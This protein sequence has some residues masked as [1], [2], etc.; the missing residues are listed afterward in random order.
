MIRRIALAAL[1]AFLFTPRV[2]GAAE[3]PPKPTA[4]EAKVVAAMSVD[5]QKRFPTPKDAETAGYVRYT[6]EDETGA[7]SYANPTHL[8]STDI[9]DPSQL[10][11]DVNGKLLGVDYAVAREAIGI[12]PALFGFD[13]IRAHKLGA[14]VHYVLKNADGTYTYGRAVG[15][16]KYTDAGLDPTK[17]DAASIVKLG[18]AK[19]A[20]DVVA[21]IP[22]TNMWD[23]TVW[24]VPNPDGAFA[25]A[26]P[27]VKPSA[28]AA[29]G[30]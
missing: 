7:I 27:N 11:Y 10:W 16:K 14:H 13:A 18:T 28:T 12:P 19:S 24:A 30:H 8:I 4:A 17:P 1:T 5:L 26:N 9:K 21:I 20:A 22:F 15:A 23:I 25:D 3:L 2:A 6:N 29:A